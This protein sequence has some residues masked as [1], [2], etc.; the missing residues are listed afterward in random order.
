MSLTDLNHLILSS[1]C[2]S[3]ASVAGWSLDPAVLAPLGIGLVVYVVGISKLWRHAGIGHGASILQAI[4]F[5]LGWL[6]MA[7]AIASPLHEIS[8]RLFAMHMLEHELV[9]TIAAPLLVFSRPL[10]P[11]LWAFPRLWRP[12]V[13]RAART[14]AYLLGWDILSRPL[15]ATL[16]HAAAIWLWHIPAVFDAALDNEMLHWL[17]HVSFLVTA[18]FFWW[19][20][21]GLRQKAGVAIGELFATGMQTGALGVLLALARQ[22]M[23]PAQAM[24]ARASG[25]DPLQDQQL[26][27]LVM[28]VPAG[29]VYVAA[30]LA[31]AGIWIANSS[32]NARSHV[33][34]A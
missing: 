11:M 26:A 34:S 25:V 6:C 17:Q 16:V 23:Y 32:H 27:G 15:V 2:F 19:S 21:L 33:P 7:V 31:I 22:P 4:F 9:M 1:G 29:L 20:L 3:G 14:G 30:A 24:L 13:A 10:G 5:A 18:M 28:W 8:E 12:Q